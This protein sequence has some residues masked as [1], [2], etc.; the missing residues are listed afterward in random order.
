MVFNPLT[1]ERG[2]HKILE[3]LSLLKDMAAVRTL[4]V[5]FN[6]SRSDF[7]FAQRAD[8]VTAVYDGKLFCILF[9]N[10]IKYITIFEIFHRKRS[11]NS[12]IY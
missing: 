6:I 5:R 12:I 3:L 9:H 2:E 1:G 8:D 11:K 10:G 7:L 4:T